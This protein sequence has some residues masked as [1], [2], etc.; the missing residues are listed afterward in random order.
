MP[1]E[2]RDRCPVCR[3]R[4]EFVTMGPFSIGLIK[5]VHPV[6]RCVPFVEPQYEPED[7]YRPRSVL[8]RGGNSPVLLHRVCALASCGKPFD[9]YAPAKK[10]CSD[11]C[12][13]ARRRECN[14]AA[15]LRYWL[16]R[17]VREFR[18]RQRIER[19]A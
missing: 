19:A 1:V 11:A 12:R 14:R 6:G 9:T 8:Q 4:Y 7:E 17:E 2:N 18:R 13:K 16:N 5:P 10:C 3:R 15:N